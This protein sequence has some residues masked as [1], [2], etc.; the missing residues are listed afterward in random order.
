MPLCTAPCRPGVTIG[1]LLSSRWPIRAL[2]VSRTLTHIT[3]ARSAAQVPEALLR[4]P[5]ALACHADL[6]LPLRVM[7]LVIACR[8]VTP[9]F[10]MSFFERADVM[11]TL[12]A[13]C[14]YQS[15]SL[16]AMVWL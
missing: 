1:V 7:T 3:S 12:S 6:L 5:S 8:I 13:G 9:A 2:L 11:H 15:P 4:N 14:A 10:S 16:A